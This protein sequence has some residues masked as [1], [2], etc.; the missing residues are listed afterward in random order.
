MLH[1]FQMREFR[2]KRGRREKKNKALGQDKRAEMQGHLYRL[3]VAREE[4]AIWF[5][6]C[7]RSRCAAAERAPGNSCAQML[8]LAW[9]GSQTREAPP[10]LCSSNPQRQLPSE[11]PAPSPWLEMRLRY[12]S[13][14][15]SLPHPHA[16]AC[17]AHRL[18]PSAR[19]PAPRWPWLLPAENW[20]L[21]RWPSLLHFATAAAWQRCL[22][23]C[24]W[25]VFMFR[26]FPGKASRRHRVLQICPSWSPN[27]GKGLKQ[28]P[29]IR[30]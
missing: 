25:H 22:F 26:S 4:S 3:T 29:V 9:G 28:M 13:S 15:I 20:S 10:A 19:A 14:F 5:H 8:A 21:H 7:K 1:C 12:D 30:V 17:P 27:Q 23:S 24:C 11:R 18:R 6:C 2:S 16:T